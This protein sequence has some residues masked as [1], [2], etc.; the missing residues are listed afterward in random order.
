MRTKIKKQDLLLEHKLKHKCKAAIL[1]YFISNPKTA[2]T[3]TTFIVRKTPHEDVLR[4][5][6]IC[7]VNELVIDGLLKYVEINNSTHIVRHD[8]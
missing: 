1:H 7:C 5:R 6:I 4:E 3:V 2:A 8:Y